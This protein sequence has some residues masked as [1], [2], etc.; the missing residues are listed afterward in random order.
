MVSRN[1]LYVAIGV[2]VI[3]GVALGYQSYQE[4][5][6]ASGLQIDVGSGGISVQGK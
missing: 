6:K 4:R 5:Q 3:V 1:F 2:L